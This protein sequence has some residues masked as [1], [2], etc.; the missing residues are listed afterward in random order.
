VQTIHAKAKTCP[1]CRALI[2]SR[3][4]EDGESPSGVAEA[5]RVSRRTVQ[6]WLRRFREFGP[7]G[8][9]DRS[10]APISKP[11]KQ[12]QP[13]SDLNTA[14][15]SLL[16]APPSEYGFNRT[17][18]RMRDLKTVLDQQGKTATL[19]NIRASI[20]ST[21]FKWKRARIALTSTDP[22]YRT[23]LDAI[24]HTLTHLSG[25]EAFFSIDEMGP[26]AVKMRAGRSLQ[27]S[28]Q[29]RTIPQ[30][31]RSKGSFILSAALELTR[32]RVTWFFSE[33]KNTDET[34]RLL[35]LL[36]KHYTR[37]GRLFV[38][39]DAAPWHDSARLW[40]TLATWNTGARSGCGPSIEVLPLP[41]SSQFLNVIESVFSG[42]ARAV[43]HNSDYASLESAQQAVAR[44]LDDRNATYAANPRPAGKLIWGK[45]RVPPV[46]NESNNCKDPRWT[47]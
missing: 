24:Q 3:V 14:V 15:V 40:E 29:V 8:L 10:S 16:H 7:A 37:Y 32:N 45:E 41:S 22:T 13:G 25:D 21:G 12:L 36:R 31:Q 5:F 27:A 34:L 4:L 39:W 26:V 18:W 30:W 2:V 11:R 20:R 35:D 43:L 46:F 17:S 28:N 44:Y 19:N 42:V 47:R 23:K 1:H 38:T 9:V 33:K 6:K